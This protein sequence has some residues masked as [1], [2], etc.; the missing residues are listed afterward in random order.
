MLRRKSPSF[1]HWIHGLR[2]QTLLE[3]H[4]KVR[5]SGVANVVE[6]RRALL[7]C[8]VVLM[9]AQLEA[10]M[11]DLFEEA[12]RSRYSTLSDSDLKE[13][14]NATTGRFN[15][16]TAA[17][18]NAL[19]FNLGIP[20]IMSQVSWTG[21]SVARVER[22]LAELNRARH[23]VAHGRRSRKD[24]RVNRTAVGRWEVLVQGI[25]HEVERV[26]EAE[27]GTRRV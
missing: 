2:V 6:T 20:R 24:P 1:L 22:E 10:C 18:I 26:L 9:F 16:P 27:C 4:A 11:E 7:E 14:F 21:W 17:R 12:A 8:A 15:G 25:V 3:A 19:F 23:A 5:T 13:L